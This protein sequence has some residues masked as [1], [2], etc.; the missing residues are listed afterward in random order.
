MEDGLAL[1]DPLT[2]QIVE[3]I[4]I[5]ARPGEVTSF[6]G[7][8]LLIFRNAE[9]D[10]YRAYDL[11]R[12]EFIWERNLLADILRTYGVSME[13]GRLLHSGNKYC[14]AAV[15]LEGTSK[16]PGDTNPLWFSHIVQDALRRYSPNSPPPQPSPKKK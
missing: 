14:P 13:D 3:R 12:R 6:T 7:G 2:G 4:P 9:G 5:V 10:P 11:V 16:R 8:D 15:D 1:A